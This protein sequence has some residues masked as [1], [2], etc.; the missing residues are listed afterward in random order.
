L[1]LRSA[2]AVLVVAAL[3]PPVAAADWSVPLSNRQL[4]EEARWSKAV[5]APTRCVSQAADYAM[6]SSLGRTWLGKTE[7]FFIGGRRH[8]QV[9]L[10]P[11]TCFLL[12]AKGLP[13]WAVIDGVFTLAHESVHVDG[14]FDEGTAECLG[15]GRFDRV[16]RVAGFRFSKQAVAAFFAGN[17]CRR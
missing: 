3:L 12:R 16:A 14:E 1:I 2:L 6:T 7:E 10:S 9:L 8:V 4:E 5:R 15:A 11:R 17:A 13:E